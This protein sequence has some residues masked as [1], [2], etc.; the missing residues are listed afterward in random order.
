MQFIN[1]KLCG[2]LSGYRNDYSTQHVLLHAIEKWKVVLDNVQHVGV[3]LMDPSKAFDAIPDSLLLT[4]LYTYDISRIAFLFNQ[5]DAKSYKLD[6]VRS[7]WKS[8][9][10]GVPPGFQTDPRIFK[11]FLNDLFYFLEG[12]FQRTNCTDDKSRSHWPWR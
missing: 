11:I 2:L 12:I 1:E 3:V 8:A 7:S 4:K 5:Q 6:V 9:V 10:L